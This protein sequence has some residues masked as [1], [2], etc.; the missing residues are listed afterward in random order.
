METNLRVTQILGL[1]S[2]HCKV[3][4]ITM[5]EDMKENMLVL[6]DFIEKF[7]REIDY[8]NKQMGILEPRCTI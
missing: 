2:K 3:A 4:I 1:R 6:N 7:S 8:K 5:F